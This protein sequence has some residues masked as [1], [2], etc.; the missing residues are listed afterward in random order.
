MHPA[1]P[2]L[3]SNLSP[4][5]RRVRSWRRMAAAAEEEHFVLRVPNRALADRIRRIVREE[6]PAVPIKL[7]FDGARRP[8]PLSRL[9]TVARSHPPCECKCRR[10]AGGPI[11]ARRS[12][13]PGCAAGPA[14]GCGELQDVSSAW[15]AWWYSRGGIPSWP[16]P[17][18]RTARPPA[19]AATMTLTL[20]SARTSGRCAGAALTRRT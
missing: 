2:R 11:H 9:S 12:G 8:P 18:A 7:Q 4:P 17:P 3:S 14:H 15:R 10:G 19:R 1:L 16:P 20:S 5:K 13:A 6:E